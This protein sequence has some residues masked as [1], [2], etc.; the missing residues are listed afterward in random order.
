[1]VLPTAVTCFGVLVPFI[2]REYESANIA[3]VSWIPGIA[4]AV[5]NLTGMKLMNS[6]PMINHKTTCL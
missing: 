5:L 3:G 2:I 6:A 4:V 1:M